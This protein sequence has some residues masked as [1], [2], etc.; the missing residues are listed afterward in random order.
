MKKPYEGLSRYIK[1][2][3]II[4]LIALLGLSGELSLIGHYETGWQVA[5]L[6]FTTLFS[7]LLI[8]PHSKETNFLF[9]V[10]QGLSVILILLGVV[11]VLLHL[12]NNFEFEREMY[13][14]ESISLLLERSITGALPTL[15]PGTLIPIGLSGLLYL[16]LKSFNRK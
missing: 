11:G 13:P 8:F 4:L 9:K 12:K 15:A 2:T 1:F 5:P 16:N 3:K 6:I 14:N 10:I 7:I